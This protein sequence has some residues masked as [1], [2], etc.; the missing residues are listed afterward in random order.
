MKRGCLRGSDF[1]LLSFIFFNNP[2]LSYPWLLKGKALASPALSG[3]RLAGEQLEV[4]ARQCTVL[5]FLC[6][7]G[8][9]Q[10]TLSRKVTV[11]PQ[12]LIRRHAS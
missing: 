7:A 5:G 8:L 2:V 3:K 12:L 9:S 6:V 11:S 4:T 10:C 1:F